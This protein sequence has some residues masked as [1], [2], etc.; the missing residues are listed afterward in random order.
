[1]VHK[2]TAAPSRPHRD[3]VF[4][5]VAPLLGGLLLWGLGLHPQGDRDLL[6]G[7]VPLVPLAALS[8][9]ELLRRTRPRPGASDRRGDRGRLLRPRSHH[10]TLRNHRE[11]ADAARLRAEQTALLAEVDRREAVVAERIQMARELHDMVANHLSAIAIH[12]AAALTMAHHD[13]A[14][15]EALGVIRENSVQGLPEV[16]Q[17]RHRLA[18]WQALTTYFIF[19][20]LRHKVELHRLTGR[21]IATR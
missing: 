17:Q 13:G 16:R 6:P 20:E 18:R 8:A 3:D 5:A 11:A 10:A 14:A 2:G 19:L 12:S 1:M 21:V 15:R 9:L 4:F 7:W